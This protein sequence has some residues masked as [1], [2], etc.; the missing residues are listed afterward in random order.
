MATSNRDRVS[1][2]L[3]MLGMGL[4]SFIDGEMRAFSPDGTRWMD[5]IASQGG[6]PTRKVSLDDPHFQLKVLWD[7]WNPVFSKILGHAERTMVSIL[8]DA[9]NKWAH[10]DSFDFDSTWRALDAANGLLTAISAVEMSAKVAAIKD[11]LLRQHYEEQARRAS[12]APSVV[13]APVGGLSAWRDV[14]MPHEDVTSGQLAQAE[15]AADL[16]QVHRGEGAFEYK[17]PEEFFKRTYLTVGLRRLIVEAVHR[18]L[19][20]PPDRAGGA[21]DIAS[22][23]PAI[24]GPHNP[25]P[26]S[27]GGSP[28]IP[29]INLQTNFGGGKTHALLTLYHLCGG[30]QKN[31]YP[32]EV[33]DAINEGLSIAGPLAQ[34][35]SVTP[36]GTK[37]ARAVIVGTALS[38]GQPAIKDD[39]TEVRTMWGELAWQ[40]GENSVWKDGPSGFKYVAEADRTATSPGDALRKLL[41]DLDQ[42]ILILI[43]EWVAYARQLYG[44]D[45]LPGGSFDTHFTFAQ[46]LTEAVRAIP[47]ALLA[48]ALP[49]GDGSSGGNT[50]IEVGGTGGQEALARLRNVVGRVESAWRPATGEES[51]EIVRRRLFQP[52][53]SSEQ[54]HDRDVTARRFFDFYRNQGETFP[55]DSRNDGYLER[56]KAAYPIHP[57]LF[58]R[59]YEDWSTLER[60]Q[61]TRGV[62]RLMAAVVHSLWAG[63]DQ[64]PLILPAS[65][66][67]DDSDVL[68]ELTHYLE[69]TWK[70]IVDSDID[71]D[72]SL[73]VEIDRDNPT[74]GRYFAA[75]RV[76]RSIFLGSAPTRGSANR[77]VVDTHI[78][79]S[80][81]YP[82]EAIPTFDDALRRLSDRATYLYVDA[83]RYWYDTQPSVAR[84]ARER[85]ERYLEQVDGDVTEEI[86]KRLRKDST[87]SQARAEFTA[88]HLSPTSSGDVPDENDGVR[89]VILGPGTPHVK[90]SDDSA[91]LRAALELL[92]S[93]GSSPRLYRNMIVFLAPEQRPLDD[94][95]QAT[96]E[97]LAWSSIRED[98]TLL[99]LNHDQESH[100]ETKINQADEVVQSRLANT[101]QW[102]LVPSQPDPAGEVTIDAARVNGKGSL[103]ARASAAL[104]HG[105][106]LN[107]E[108]NPYLLRLK[109]DETPLWRGNHISV[110]EL[111][112]LMARYPYL[113]RLSDRKVLYSA[114]ENST[115]QMGWE[116][117]GFALADR[118]DESTQRYTGLTYY[119]RSENVHVTGDTLVVQPAAAMAQINADRTAILTGSGPSGQSST[120][121]QADIDLLEPGQDANQ[122]PQSSR[123]IGTPGSGSRRPRRFHGSIVLHSDRLNRDFGQVVQEIVQQLQ[124]FDNA[125][126][127]DVEVTVEISATSNDGFDDAVMRTVTENARTLRFR[128]QGFEDE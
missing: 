62:L 25:V 21:S 39:G 121:S 65:V 98:R 66:P 9:R 94:L 45:D 79:L 125:N 47:M 72:R 89:L 99:N 50:G 70:P 111:W 61:Q 27:M 6:G 20:R 92:E 19:Y 35:G 93:R 73:P 33:L 82:G 17:D 119:G 18:L 12:R 49:A 38:P 57:E 40:L 22:Y 13:N 3:E 104:V 14:V 112:E 51:F 113:P 15:F 97:Y 34:A 127:A 117:E 37:Y 30:L 124:R 67:L 120:V 71:G 56:I 46:T 88:V 106:Y 69:D 90:S 31:Q 4:G 48:I 85:T 118:F 126:S 60:F 122:T 103:A 114:V 36:L 108:Y 26:A 7:Y 75:R 91:A 102:L 59:L 100:V 10:N 68:N 87:G 42:P 43:D 44:R 105:N 64:T 101:F 81:V 11:D 80:S 107:V 54:F 58:A 41:S 53:T 8:M 1:K 86:L 76:A 95:F 52:M 32:T 115:T 28:G 78:R 74:F 110:E 24:R 29:V 123:P 96:A 116:S 128:D 77:G 84:T 16:A 83:R 109:L 5:T 55:S 23:D 63:G 2:A